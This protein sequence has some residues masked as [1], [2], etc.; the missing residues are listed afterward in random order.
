T[1]LTMSGYHGDAVPAMQKRMIDAVAAMPGV[2][3]A[4]S[5]DQP[6]LWAGWSTAGVYKDEATDLRPVNAAAQ[7]V[8]YKIS[9][10]YF[11]AAGTALLAGRML[12]SHDDKN[13]PP[14][15]VVNQDFA[16]RM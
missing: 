8:F 11:R 10:G 9:P 14:V 7:A 6:P 4:G 1:D 13:V 12:T 15:A 3:A 16:R 2:E 5:I